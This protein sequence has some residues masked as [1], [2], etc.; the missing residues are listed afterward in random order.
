MIQHERTAAPLARL[1]R[2]STIAGVLGVVLCALGAAWDLDQF[3]QSYLFGY[4]LWVGLAVGSLAWLMLQ[5]L[6]GGHWAD[7]TRPH[8]SAAART[9]PLMTLL[10]VPLLFGL[11]RLY[12][13]ARLAPPEGWLTLLGNLGIQGL[14][15]SMW[16]MGESGD[17][18]LRHKS[19]Y[20]NIPFFLC[21]AVAYFF[22]WCML[23]SYLRRRSPRSEDREDAPFEARPRRLRLLSAGGLVV[24][25][26]TLTF[27][28]IDW[29]MS[30]EPRWFSSIYGFLVGAG[31][32]LGALALVVAVVSHAGAGNDGGR[33]TASPE[34]TRDLG[35]L[36]LTFVM[37]WAYV[38]FSQFFLIWSGN[39]P[40]EIEW[41]LHRLQGGWGALAVA[42]V[43]LHFAVPF[44]LL[45]S[46]QIKRHAP[47]LGAVAVGLFAMHCVNVFWLVAPAF[48][49]G[50]F[51]VHWL[52]VAA[53]TAI[54]GIWLS[55]F[56]RS[57]RASEPQ[58][59]TAAQN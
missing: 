14:Y 38:S 46:R 51:R 29:L 9:L 18:L 30:L 5:Y 54:G 24:L 56:A 1:G 45:L 40:E 49:P 53:P 31:A 28:S 33:S 4:A 27:A 6:T 26:L 17:E 7:A 57:L 20:L 43:V 21:R 47:A 35:N 39:L 44:L 37:I 52:D 32:M 13:W 8:F 58:A 11:Q 2:R 34:V 22:A 50:T 55:V 23:G 10:F 25:A 16:P 42:L 59:E 48:H 12:E 19:V 3:F 36:L 41:Y 15:R